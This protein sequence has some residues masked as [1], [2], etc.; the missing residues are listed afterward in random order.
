MNGLFDAYAVEVKR[1]SRNDDGIIT[2][3]SEVEPAYGK[4]VPSHLPHP[5]GPP[6]ERGALRPGGAVPP[7]MG[8]IDPRGTDA[9]R[10]ITYSVA[11]WSEVLCSDR[12]P[13]RWVAWPAAVA[14]V[15]TGGEINV[16]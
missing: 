10:A 2:E 13:P 3:K 1:V 4:H 6:R 14:R 12:A 16:C 9:A 5:R 15:G 7:P 11:T 8:R